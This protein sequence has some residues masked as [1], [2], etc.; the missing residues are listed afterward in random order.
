MKYKNE[1]ISNVVQILSGYAFDS[2]L[3]NNEKNGLPLIR[4]RDVNSGFTGVYYSGEY[5]PSYIINKG[6]VL[7]SLDGDFK[8]IAWEGERALLNQRVCK[9]TPDQNKLYK[10]FLLY[11]LPQRLTRIHKNTDFTT[12]K[13]LS[14]NILR[15]INIPLPQISDQIKIATILYKSQLLKRKRNESINLLESYVDSV[16]NERFIKQKYKSIELEKLAT[17]ITDGEHLKPDYQEQ[18]VPFI[19]VTNITK[20]ILNFDNT[21]FVSK[22]DFEKHIKRCNPQKNDILY[23]KVGATYGRAVLVDTDR[24]FSLYVSVALIKPNHNIVNASFLKF[25][26]N[27]LYVKRQADKSVKGAGVPNLHLIDIKKI[28]IPLPTITE[29]NDFF[30]IV[31]KYETLLK[32][33][34]DSL[35]HLE[36]L[37]G[38]LTQKAFN[39][40]LDLDGLDVLVEEY[41]SSTDNDRTEPSHFEKPINWELVEVKPKKQQ[42]ENIEVQNRDLTEKDFD[43][44]LKSVL[45]EKKNRFQFNEFIDLLSSKEVAFEYEDIRDFIFQKLEQKKLVQY[46]SSDYW[47]NNNYK[48]ETNPLQDDFS[49][50][51]G[52]IWLTA[53]SIDK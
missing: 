43:T 19:S 9:L 20:G 50:T 32:L 35:K 5:D 28:K 3:F 48:P 16:F 42:V 13:H 44:I 45:H 26:L 51:D 30:L 4:V 31:E 15:S 38:G 7:V 33:L 34:K 1:R 29:Q 37:I 52:N 36:N 39:G 22:I 2:T 24:P 40:D 41:Y 21:K 23:S 11:V 53:N 8:C 17:K 10:N 46:Y 12:V 47:M 49:G 25:A 18:G 6:D 14:V 27:H